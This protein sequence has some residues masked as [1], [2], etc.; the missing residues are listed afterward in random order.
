MFCFLIQTRYKSAILGNIINIFSTKTMID[1]T[2]KHIFQ[3]SIVLYRGSFFN[4]ISIIFFFFVNWLLKN[5]LLFFSNEVYK[6]IEKKISSVLKL[7]WLI[8]M[9]KEFTKNMLHFFSLNYFKVFYMSLNFLTFIWL[10][11]RVH[12]N[13]IEV[14]RAHT[15]KATQNHNTGIC[16]KYFLSQAY[17]NFFLVIFFNYN[18]LLLRF[19]IIFFNET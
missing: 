16:C 9:V 4:D 14:Q 15:V 2:H 17:I 18:I 10:H 6:M 8:Y 3:A 12:E 19:Y 7:K 11:F 5:S 13:F 1:D